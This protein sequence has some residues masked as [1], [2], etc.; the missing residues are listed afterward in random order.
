MSNYLAIATVTAALQR[1][2]QEEIGR[3]VPGA[4]VTTMRPDNSGSNISGACVNLYLYQ[5]TPNPAW[6]NA[7]LR[8]RRP[9][10]DLIKHGQAG[11]D[12]HYLLTFYGN[13]LEL[14]PQRLM[15]STIRAL[16]DQPI[17]TREMIDDA[18]ANSSLTFLA[19]ST[20]ADQVQL[21]KFIPSAITTEDLSRIWSVFFQV[22]YS[23]S[24]AYQGTAVLI[25]G[26]KSG[27]TALPVRS[28]QFYVAPSRPVLERLDPQGAIDQQ[29]T[30]NSSLTVRGRQLQGDTTKILIGDAKLTPQEVN[31]TH[32]K[33]HLSSLPPTEARL[34]K[35][36]VQ[37]LQVI[38]LRPGQTPIDPERT[39]ESNVIP[40]VISPSIVG[41][42]NGIEISGL[43][44]DEDD[45][46]SA[47]LTL[48][49]APNVMPGQRVFL[50]LNGISADNSETYLFSAARRDA[51]T[52][53]LRFSIRD[54]RSGQYLVRIQV[55][56]AESPL[57]VDTN[58]QSP[59]FE[60]YIA[61]IISIS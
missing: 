34:L 14:E 4:Q 5:A 56:G 8:T 59:T 43:D 26:E 20:L 3:D 58:S 52:N 10:S 35:A 27:Q 41:S 51:E 25:Q 36:G 9:K 15:G 48:Q 60:Q 50:L 21:V 42:S 44:E 46:Y 22:P 28:R 11:L 12:L 29:I 7:D 61:P 30:I 57:E 47:S 13:E 17:L 23:L 16:V 31:S 1:L 53:Q 45:L 32:V 55:D 39:V 33:V 49:V 18:I 54:V 6:R 24:F 2:L 19:E 38:H 37:G 40:V